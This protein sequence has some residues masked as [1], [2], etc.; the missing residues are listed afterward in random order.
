MAGTSYFWQGGRKIEIEQSGR[1]IT[2]EAIGPEE[3]YEAAERADVAV[4]RVESVAPSLVRVELPEDRD[5]GMAK[6]R[7]SHVVHHVYHTKDHPDDQV[8]ISDTFFIKFTDDAPSHMIRRYL[9]DEHLEVVDDFGKNRLLVR[10]TDETGRN[11][12]RAANAAVRRAEVEYAEPNLVRELVKFAFL[13]SDPLFPRQ[14][15]LH[16]P[17]DAHDLVEDADINAPEAWDYTLGIRDVV[18]AVA[19]DGFD[20]THPDFQGRGKIAGRLNVIPNGSSLTYDDQVQ[21]R[22]GDY[23]GTPC[24]GVALADQ[25]GIGA[26]GV[27]PGCS[28]LAVRFPLTLSDAQLAKMFEWISA[29][30]EVVSCSWGVGPANAPM[31]TTLRERISELATSGGR[32]GKGLIF[33]VAAG[34]NNCPVKD[35]NNSQPYAYRDRFGIR[36]HYSGP[37]DRWIAAHSDVITVSA[38]TSLKTRSAYSSWGREINV[39]A[40]SNNFDDL[41]EFSP[42][43]LGIVTTDNEGFGA[44]SDFTANSRYTSRFGGTSSATPTVAGVCALVLS[45]NPSLTGRAVRQIIEQTADKDLRIE[46]ESDVNEPGDFDGN[47]F[48]LWFGYGKVNAANA[49]KQAADRRVEQVV[50]EAE[51][52]DGAQAIPDT[53][54]FVESRI[55]IRDDGELGELRVAV[56]IQHPYIGDLRVDLVAP[57]GTAVMLHNHEGGF[58]DHIQRVYTPRDLPALRAFEGKSV[59]GTWTL[60]IQ[61]TWSMDQGTLQ[62]WRLIARVAAPALEPAAPVVSRDG[63]ASQKRRRKERRAAV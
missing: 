62:G 2:V 21:P 42:R 13:P 57:D 3:V 46:S 43:G 11:P 44:S 5:R 59:R 22:A 31:A 33:C 18:V 24:A 26:V 37:I 10:V 15:H 50:V 14:W 8:L 35:L 40:P 7:E 38:S 54:E 16:A 12:I 60:R 4:E 63:Q 36:R 61:D 53:G 9:Q 19:D 56:D 39:C 58:R 25:N 23:H 6:L 52:E 27:A 34:N 45:V 32:R 20:L 17:D 41:Q 49:V 30:A 48:S 1:E 51:S 55:E 28:L 29:R 47:G